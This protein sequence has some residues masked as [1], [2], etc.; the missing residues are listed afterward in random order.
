MRRTSLALESSRASENV[1]SFTSLAAFAKSSVSLRTRGVAGAGVEADR[2]D[3]N[4]E[5]VGCCAPRCES[6]RYCHAVVES[7]THLVRPPSGLRV[8]I[9]AAI[10]K[11][12]TTTVMISTANTSNKDASMPMILP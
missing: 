3:P 7:R 2:I 8:R 10:T 11:H 9:T 6:S 1:I 5:S 12:A 4:F